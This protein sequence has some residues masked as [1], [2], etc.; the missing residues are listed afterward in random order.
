M[1]KYYL[2][3]LSIGILVVSIACNKKEDKDPEALCEDALDFNQVNPTS[4]NYISGT[5]KNQPFYYWDANKKFGNYPAAL[6]YL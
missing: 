2:F 4:V 6:K 3:L 1:K 5:F